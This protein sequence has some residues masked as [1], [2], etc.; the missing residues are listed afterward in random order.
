[1][2]TRSLLIVD[3][4]GTRPV[5]V[6][7]TS[8]GGMGEVG[9]ALPTS[10]S[11][12]FWR[13]KTRFHVGLIGSLPLW[14]GRLHAGGDSFPIASRLSETKAFQDEIVH[15]YHLKADQLIIDDNWWEGKV[16]ASLVDEG[17]MKLE[18]GGA[19][20][21]EMAPPVPPQSISAAAEEILRA[22]VFRQLGKVSVSG[23]QFFGSGE[24][25]RLSWQG[26]NIKTPSHLGLIANGLLA[27]DDE[28]I[29]HHFG[30]CM[31]TPQELYT[32]DSFKAEILGNLGLGPPTPCKTPTAKPEEAESLSRFFSALRSSIGLGPVSVELSPIGLTDINNEQGEAISTVERAQLTRLAWS[33]LLFG[34][35]ED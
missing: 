22:N 28:G 3:F 10:L 29:F 35:C 17:E 31:L 8:D 4:I 23:L 26:I 24:E 27:R 6:D 5:C 11:S 34:A 33:S 1:M 14:K 13:A 18:F 19:V 30:L 7:F 20:N 9:C 25:R 21:S 32:L 15:L 12:S 16:T 2:S